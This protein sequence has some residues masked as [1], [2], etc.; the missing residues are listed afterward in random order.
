MSQLAA[1][2][3]KIDAAPAPAAPAPAA[4]AP[5]PAAP[6]YTADEETAIATYRKEWPDVAAAEQLV[7]RKEYADLVN[8]IY[9]QIGPILDE[10]RV[11][12]TRAHSSTT[13]SELTRLIPDYDDVRDP[14]LEWVAKQPA[15]LKTAYEQVTE[16]GMP[17]DIADLVDRFKKD[18]GWKGKGGA[19]PAPAPAAAP[20]A[21]PAAPAVAPAV[22]AAAAGLKPVPSA[23]SAAGT[24]ADPNDYD[25]AF[26]EASAALS[27]PAA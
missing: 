3:A 15:Y 16:T 22:A 14:V 27:T 24:G 17:A 6:L 1:L 7:R 5:A 2:Q 4:P 12:S 18:T 26:K 23:R 11:T 20:V 19:A 25:G 21:A 13:Y 9:S 10:L 8:H